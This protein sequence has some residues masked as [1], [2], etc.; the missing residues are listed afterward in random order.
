MP[1]P[2]KKRAYTLI[3]LLVSAFILL[4]MVGVVFNF[5][6]PALTRFT[7]PRSDIMVEGEVNDAAAWLQSAIIRS[8]GTGNDFTLTIENQEP[9][10]FM[11]IRWR[12][13]GALER[14]S[15]NR[16]T[17]RSLNYDS[18]NSTY[19]SGFQKLTPAVTIAVHFSDGKKERTVWRISI[20]GY[21][22]VR[23]YRYS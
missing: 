7:D 14:W 6:W 20:S 3:E 18:R 15:S 9:T 12:T 11:A 13:S 8:I 10:D 21:G 5:G 22:Y 16:I 19:T 17:F 23:A 4:V 2:G 1:R